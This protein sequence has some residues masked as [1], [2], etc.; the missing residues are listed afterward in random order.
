[1]KIKIES[2]RGPNTAI[3]ADGSI[4]RIP[5]NIAHPAVGVELEFSKKDWIIGKVAKA[6]A[7]EEKPKTGEK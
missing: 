7:K 4:V 2:Y 6:E 5:V 3:G 1:M